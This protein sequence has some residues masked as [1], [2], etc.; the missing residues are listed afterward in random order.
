MGK[1]MGALHPIFRERLQQLFDATGCWANSTWRSSQEQ[2]YF[3]D[4][5][6]N[7]NCNNCNP[8]NEPGS[9][10]HEAVPWGDAMALAA[11]IGGDLNAAYDVAANYGL[12]FPIVSVEPWH[13]QP[14]EVPYAY[15]TGMPDGWGQSG[16]YTIRQGAKGQIVTDCQN[17]LNAHGYSVTVDGD[18]GPGTAAAVRQF[19]LDHGL[20][21]DGVVG[22]LTWQALDAEVD[23]PPPPPP[24]MPADRK[25]PNELRMSSQGAALIAGHEGLVLHLY[26][27]PVGHCTVGIGHLVH[28]GNCDGRD[29]ESRWAGREMSNEEA[30]QL[31]VEEDAPRYVEGVR[32]HIRVPLFQSEFDALVSFSFNLGA[33]ILDESDCTLARLLNASDYEGASNEFGKWVNAGGQRLEGLVRRRAEERELFR[34]EW[35]GSVTPTPEPD[36]APGWPGR[37]LR[38]GMTGTDVST[39]QAKLAERGWRIAA[40]GDFGAQTEGVVIAFQQ[41]KGLLSDGIVGADT[42]WAIWHVDVTSGAP[43]PRPSHPEWPGRY[44]RIGSQGEDVLLFQARLYERGWRWLDVDGDFGPNTAKAVIQ[45]QQEKGL[46]V[47]GVVGPSTWN[48]FWTAPVS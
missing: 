42:W 7:C 5:Y 45:F 8:A 13:I 39:F 14:V 26:N 28:E 46:T 10:N 33:D 25:M 29:S 40:D 12:H 16:R 2:Q 34:S 43:A 30:Y 36:G 11:D 18:F 48:S 6:V 23:A 15:Y 32:R 41:E 3:R 20:A 37:N 22:P 19:Q 35:N 17:R 24:P 31:F 1:D 4:C 38:R 44:L 27:D 9:S 47:D 21:S